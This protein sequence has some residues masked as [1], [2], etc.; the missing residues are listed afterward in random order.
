MITKNYDEEKIISELNKVK[1]NVDILRERQNKLFEYYI[2]K[3]EL[4]SLEGRSNYVIKEV[5]RVIESVMPDMMRVFLGGTDVV[6]ITPRGVEDETS[7]RLLHEKINWDILVANSGFNVLHDAIK[8]A[9]IYGYGCIKYYWDKGKKISYR[10]YSNLT[11]DEI[12][13]VLKSLDDAEIEYKV[14]SV[15]YNKSETKVIK[16]MEKSLDTEIDETALDV[17]G[18]LEIKIYEY[19]SEPRIEAVP[20]EDIFFDPTAKSLHDTFVAHRRRIH[21]DEAPKFGLK[22]SDLEDISSIDNS[23]L[24]KT[25]RALDVGVVNTLGLES[26]KKIIEIYECYYYE[27]DEDGDRVPFVCVVAGNKIVKQPTLNVYGVP[28]FVIGTPIRFGHRIVGKSLAEFAKEPQDLKTVLMRFMLDNIY[29]QNNGR[30]IIDPRAIVESDFLNNNVPGGYIRTRDGISPSQAVMPL[31]PAPI[32]PQIFNIWNISDLQS[33]QEHGVGDYMQGLDSKTLNKTATGVTQ[34]LNRSMQRVELIARTLAETLIRDLVKELINLNLSFF[35]RSIN[36]KID[37]EWISIRPEDI[38]GSY[39][40]FDVIVDIG[41]STGMRE[42]K[43]NQ[44][45]SMLQLMLNGFSLQS[46][47]ITPQNIANIYKSLWNT[48]GFKSVDR[49]VSE[50]PQQPLSPQMVQMANNGQAT[51]SQQQLTPEEQQQYMQ[52]MMAMMGNNYGIPER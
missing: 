46:G 10:K 28:P 49:F 33:Q 18:D 20:P 19:Y 30:Y 2:G 22:K 40:K 26:E 12:S 38:K 52:Q 29:F 9:L 45:I 3:T 11:T 37:E 25:S 1:S 48:L 17:R 8:D 15:K 7:A 21:I 36:I 34:I 44:L 31:M 41:A 4:S 27:Y 23:D 42:Y 39:G 50:P 14:L 35:D 24:L 51:P 16:E 5:R 6:T 13:W 32:A 47:V 43:T